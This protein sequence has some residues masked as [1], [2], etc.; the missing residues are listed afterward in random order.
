MFMRCQ[1]RG[2]SG[3]P[4]GTGS[5]RGVHHPDIALPDRVVPGM[6]PTEDP[7]LVL[8]RDGVCRRSLRPGGVLGLLRPRLAV[9]RKPDVVQG[10]PAIRPYAAA[11]DPELAVKRR[12][13][14]APTAPP[15]C[16]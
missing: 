2:Y 9:G 1:P 12:G 7:E 10:V 16:L 8:E 6:L 5:R 11:V 13:P 4:W 14:E 15:L 3:S